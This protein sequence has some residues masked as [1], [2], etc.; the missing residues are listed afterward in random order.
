MKVIFKVN[1]RD[2]YKRLLTLMNSFHDDEDSKL[3]LSEIEI[4]AEFLTLPRKK[5][6]Y[7]QFSTLAKSKVIANVADKG[8][9]MSRENLNNKVYSLVKKKILWRDADGVVYF[10][11]HIKKAIEQLRNSVDSTGKYSFEIVFDVQTE[12]KT[13]ELQSN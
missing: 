4:L 8:W 11:P 13:E 6:E 7:Q 10:M 9:S 2:A 3:T 1:E 12:D 5:F